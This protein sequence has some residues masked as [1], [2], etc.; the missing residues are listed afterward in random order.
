M[1]ISICLYPSL[2]IIFVVHA[3]G[4]RTEGR[5]NTF[6]NDFGKGTGMVPTH[7]IGSPPSEPYECCD[8]VTCV[9]FCGCF[10]DYSV[11]K[12][13]P[14]AFLSASGIIT[15]Q[16]WSLN[17]TIDLDPKTFI[18]TLDLDMAK[19]YL[20]TKNEV[21]SYCGSKVIVWRG[22]HTGRQTEKTQMKILPIHTRGW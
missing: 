15:K 12:V 22:G 4:T 13:L 9:K 3:D 8:P 2:I 5:V 20:H 16:R 21:P 14:W 11:Y 19:M 1:N 18:L 17:I 7:T 10:F 6:L